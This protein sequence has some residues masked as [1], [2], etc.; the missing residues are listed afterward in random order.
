MGFIFIR[1][2]VENWIAEL[3]IFSTRVRK[4]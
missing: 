3:D 2:F 1:K 4:E